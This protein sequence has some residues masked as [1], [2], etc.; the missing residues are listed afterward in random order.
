MTNEPTEQSARVMR[1]ERLAAALLDIRQIATSAD[2]LLA[3]DGMTDP[4]VREFNLLGALRAIRETLDDAKLDDAEEARPGVTEEEIHE[5][6]TEES[7]ALGGTSLV[8]AHVIP[9]DAP[10]AESAAEPSNKTSCTHIKHPFGSAIRMTKCGRTIVGVVEETIAHVNDADYPYAYCAT[11]YEGDRVLFS[12]E[13]CS[14]GLYFLR[15]VLKAAMFDALMK[16]T[17]I[18][19]HR[20]NRKARRAAA[21]EVR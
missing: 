21:S 1:N 11:V 3:T 6:A 9:H 13:S 17:H 7:A 4:A 12:I 15:S 16:M 10:A 18:I 5:A 14:R 8:P 20:A 19:R 2:Q